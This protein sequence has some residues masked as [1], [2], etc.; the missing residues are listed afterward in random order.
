MSILS[1]PNR[2]H[3]GNAKWRGNCSGFVYQD[4]FLRLQPKRFCDPTMGSGSA[5]EVAREMGIEA[6]GLDLHSG[7]NALKMSILDALDDNPADLVLSHPPYHD[8]ITYSGNVWGSE[9]HPDD[10]SHC[11]DVDDFN[12]KMTTVL[13]N[14]RDATTSNGIYGCIIGDQRSQG[15]YRSFQAE[16]IARMPSDELAGVLIKAQHNTQSENKS[17]GNMKGLPFITHEYILLW[18]KSAAVISWL[19]TIRDLDI[20]HYARQVS[21]WKSLVIMVMSKFKNSPVSL[22]EIYAEIEKNAGDRLKSNKHYQAKVRQV[23]NQNTVEFKQ[24]SRGVWQFAQ[25]A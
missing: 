24:V 10:L 4:L 12:E 8:V 13:F 23:L 11:L 6:I 21:S 20:K 2:G 1:F 17:Y 22:S 3:W 16:L 14:Q 19:G 15:Q 9:P 5:I 7:F 25:F 18:R